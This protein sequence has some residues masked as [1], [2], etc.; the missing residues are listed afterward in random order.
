MNAEKTLLSL[1]DIEAQTALELPDRE[2]LTCGNYLIY[3]ADS[4]NFEPVVLFAVTQQQAFQFCNF[5][6]NWFQNWNFL[7]LQNNASYQQDQW[8]SCKVYQ[9]QATINVLSQ[10]TTNNTL[11]GLW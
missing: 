1:A 6:N 8:Y 4:F 10:E 7:M 3:I 5:L 9:D 2:T 11:P